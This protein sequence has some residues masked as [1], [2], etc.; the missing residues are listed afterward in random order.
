ML[1]QIIDFARFTKTLK[2]FY[3]NGETYYDTLYCYSTNRYLYEIWYEQECYG[4][5]THGWN[6]HIVLDGKQYYVTSKEF[7]IEVAYCKLN[8]KIRELNQTQAES[9]SLVSIQKQRKAFE[10]YMKLN[11]AIHYENV[12]S[13]FI[14]CRNC[15]SKIASQYFGKTVKNNCPVCKEDLRPESLLLKIAKAKKNYKELSCQMFS[16][17]GG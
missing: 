17:K 2:E 1:L 14:S 13:N 16:K 6:A 11:T 4:N 7:S 8:E 12:K 15:G 10:R 9:E 3:Y 5:D